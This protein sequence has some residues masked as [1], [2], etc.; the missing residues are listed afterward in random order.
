MTER[1]I[2]ASEEMMSDERG[3]FIWG[4]RLLWVDIIS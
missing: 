2:G 3:E 1:L 4:K